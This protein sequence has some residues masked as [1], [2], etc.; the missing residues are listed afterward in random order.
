MPLKK[1]EKS[2]SKKG[3][4]TLPFYIVIAVVFVLFIYFQSSRYISSILGI[5]LFMII[6]VV[7]IIELLNGVK[8]EG[9]TK[10]IIEIIIAV[11]VV[12]AL[13]F[14]L[15]FFLHTNNP[16]DIVPSCSMLPNLK[17][18]DLIVL[19]GVTNIS[20]VKAPI[21]NI[22]KADYNTMQK[23]IKSEFLSCVAYNRTG[24]EIQVSQLIKPG[25][26][27]GLLSLSS[28]G[29]Q[30][31]N[32]QNQQNNLIKYACGA[33]QIQYSN[34]T[35]ASEAYTTSVTINGTTLNGD[36]NNTIVV[37]Q[38]IPQ[39]YFY[40]LGDSYIVHRVYAVLNVSGVYY[41]LTK[42]DNNPGLDMQYGN[43]P[44]NLTYIQGKELLSIPYLGYIKLVL[45]NSFSEP[46]GCNSTVL[47][48]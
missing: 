21:I 43:Y 34:G 39:D 26:S 33:Q 5:A 38:T 27:V 9:V 8:E 37:Y 40:Q 36:R 28:T 2:K 48:N 41:I 29:G 18:G 46:S 16:I 12:L 15:R 1:N 45:S 31:V 19:H 22:S 47:D 24:N 3:M 14:G 11:F 10:N 35:T 6:I 30:I 7:I 13:W 25:Y 20:E 44:V 42:G 23:N 4:N 17:R 32:Q